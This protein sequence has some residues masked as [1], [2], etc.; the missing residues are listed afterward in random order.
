MSAAERQEKDSTSASHG[1]M[2]RIRDSI[3]PSVRSVFYY[4]FF[5]A[6][7]LGL[8]PWAAHQ[9]GKL[10]PWSMEIGWGRTLGWI[11][12]AVMYV[13]YTAASVVLVRR[14]RGTYVEF[15]PPSE[16]VASG[17]FRWCRNPIAACVLGMVLGEALAFSSIGI[18]L[19]FLVGV[20]LANLQVVRLEE[21]LLEER[22]GQAYL[23][24]KKT[25]PRWIPRLPVG[26]RS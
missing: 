26:K 6:F 18:M 15:D 17:P 10:L 9:G 1:V 12:F 21:P 23:D 20:P 22:F 16:F 13:L 7:I 8:I 2:A 19:L 3:P 14:G 5:L 25:T 4:F 24:Y 11:I